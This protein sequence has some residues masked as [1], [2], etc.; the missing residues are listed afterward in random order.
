MKNL[1]REVFGS[2]LSVGADQ[3]FD[4]QRKFRNHGN[5]NGDLVSRREH[6]AHLG[7][8]ALS[9]YGIAETLKG[10]GDTGLI[11]QKPVQVFLTD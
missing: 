10:F 11:G 7:V 1:V 8:M 3:D 9:L 6:E 5:G 2:V 4:R